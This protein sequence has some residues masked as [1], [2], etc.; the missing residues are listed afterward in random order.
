M[1]KR[2]HDVLPTPR[3]HV[4]IVTYG[5]SGS[6][7]TQSL[8]NT[9]PGYQIRGENGNLAWFLARAVDLVQRHEMFAGRRRDAALPAGQRD[10]YLAPLIGQ[11]HDPWAGAENVDPDALRRGLMEVFSREVLRPGP[12]CRVSGFKEIRFHEDPDF[13]ATYLNILR[14]SFAGTRF[15]FQTRNLEAVV[16]SGWWAQQPREQVVAQLRRAEELFAD[17]AAAQPEACFTIRHERY[18]E[19]ADYVAE[20]LDFLGEQM[21]RPAIEAALARSLSH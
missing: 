13:F 11:P 6:T 8:L 16:R 5:R 2:A 10:A 21:D 19:G 14:D 1:Q 3:A 9:L 17:Y 20:I 12:D 15:L 18:R 7:L 4:F